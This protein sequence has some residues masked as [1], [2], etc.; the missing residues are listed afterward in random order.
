M[1]EISEREFKKIV[2]RETVFPTRVKD[3]KNTMQSQGIDTQ[4]FSHVWLD[5][6]NHGELTET[7]GYFVQAAEP[8]PH[9]MALPDFESENR[10]ETATRELLEFLRSIPDPRPCH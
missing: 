1:R 7:P 8:H 4:L 5:L 2:L 9:Q 3:L 10:H 6:T